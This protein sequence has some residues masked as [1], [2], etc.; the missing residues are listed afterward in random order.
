MYGKDVYI[1][2]IMQHIEE[3][4]IHSGDLGVCITNPS[5]LSD[6]LVP[7]DKA[8]DANTRRANSFNRTDDVL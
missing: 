7:G 1:G 3:A 4:G 8:T 2:G 5:Q 6:S